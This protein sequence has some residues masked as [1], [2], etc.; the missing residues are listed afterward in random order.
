MKILKSVF[1]SAK[2]RAR[3]LIYSQ[4]NIVCKSGSSLNVKE[5]LQVGRKWNSAD[6][7]FTSF[8]IDKDSKVNIGNMKIF[9][10]CRLVIKKNA[11]F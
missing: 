11:I 10:G 9:Y 3:V 2:T 4:S 6:M 1:Y 5:Q 7:G 8:F